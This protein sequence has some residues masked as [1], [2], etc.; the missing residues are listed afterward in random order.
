VSILATI[1]MGFLLGISFLLSVTFSIQDPANVLSPDN[2]VGG[3]NPVM[4]IVWDAFAARWVLLWVLHN[5]TATVAGPWF[6]A[7]V[8]RGRSKWQCHLASS[9]LMCRCGIAR[10]LYL[11]GKYPW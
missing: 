6:E 10:Q 5:I 9:S 2:A 4:G 8:W 7:T 1:S 11:A 3:G